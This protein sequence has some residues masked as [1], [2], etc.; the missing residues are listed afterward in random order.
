MGHYYRAYYI[1]CEAWKPPHSARQPWRP[2]ERQGAQ[3]VHPGWDA[4]DRR[5]CHGPPERNAGRSGSTTF[6]PKP[7]TTQSPRERFYSKILA[8]Y[9]DHP[10][11]ALYEGKMR[12][13][14][15]VGE[16][17]E[18]TFEDA[19]TGDVVDAKDYK[20]KVLLVVFWS[21]TVPDCKRQMKEA[22]RLWFR[23]EH[24]G[25]EVV[26]VSLDTVGGAGKKAYNE[27]VKDNKMDWKHYFQGSGLDSAFS[28]SWGVNSLPTWFLIDRKGKLRYTDANWAPRTR[29]RS[30]S[31]K[32]WH[33]PAL[34]PLP[35]GTST[36]W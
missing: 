30:L 13:D 25:M 9:P 26:D 35:L 21:Y 7:A 2:C 28:K 19:L 22:K 6:S 10:N 33:R 24:E 34:V 11:K 31:K 5:L 16:P 18:M 14:D 3:D 29:S 4:C 36:I 17:F 32:G 1:L 15:K 12:R 27:F 8:D 23:Y 20:D